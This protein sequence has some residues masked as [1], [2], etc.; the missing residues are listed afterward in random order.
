MKGK[1]YFKNSLKMGHLH[2]EYPQNVDI[3]KKINQ[4]LN[5]IKGENFIEDTEGE[6]HSSAIKL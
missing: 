3:Y 5:K 1:T 2:K 4:E 6:Y